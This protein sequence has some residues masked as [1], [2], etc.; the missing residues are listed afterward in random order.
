MREQQHRQ[1][2]MDGRTTKN[3]PFTGV[4]D[5]IA[6]WV[7]THP[8]RNVGDLFRD[9]QNLYPGRNQPGQFRTLQ[10]GVGKIRTCLLEIENE[11]EWKE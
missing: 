2:C 4:W 10:R 8:K 11:Y 3:D 7:I 5:Q 6:S 1:H 9:L